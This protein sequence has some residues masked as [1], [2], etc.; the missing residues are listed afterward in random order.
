MSF[1]YKIIQEKVFKIAACLEEHFPHSVANAIVHQ[2]EVENLKHREEHE[3]VSKI[4][5]A[6]HISNKLKW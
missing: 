6:Q 2:A 5:I 1:L 3:E 4:W